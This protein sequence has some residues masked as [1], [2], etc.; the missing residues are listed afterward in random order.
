MQS[1]HTGTRMSVGDDPARQQA[2]DAWSLVTQAPQS[3]HAWHRFFTAVQALTNRDRVQ[4]AAAAQQARYPDA[5]SAFL[6]ST[7]VHGITRDAADLAGAADVFMNS[8]LPSEC[9]LALMNTI[10]AQALKSCGSH[11]AMHRLFE[12]AKLPQV[13]HALGHRLAEASPAGHAATSEVGVPAKRA[14]VVTPAVSYLR[15]HAPTQMAV[16]QARQLRR[17]GWQVSML[18]AQEFAPLQME[19]WLG[20]ARAMVLGAPRAPELAA[21]RT[22]MPVYL[23]PT[24]YSMEVRWRALIDKVREIR[25]QVVL[26]VGLCS[27]I[28]SVLYRDHAVV[29]L[30]T[31]TGLLVAGPHDVALVGEAGDAEGWKGIA[32][33]AH[34]VVHTRR[35]DVDVSSSPRPLHGLG[36]PPDALVW[37]SSGTRLHEEMLPSWTSRVLGALEQQPDAHW[38]IVGV[39]AQQQRSLNIM[40]PRVHFVPYDT[41][42]ASWMAASDIYLAPPRVGGG[43]SVCM[44]MAHGLAVVAPRTGDAGNKL[45][46]RAQADEEGC[47]AALLRYSAEPAERAACGQ[48]LR[49]RFHAVYAARDTDTALGDA[50]SLAQATA[51]QRL[52]NAPRA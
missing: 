36:I 32:P 44:A 29:G 47:F 9:G 14:V 33:P 6:A 16:L 22:E 38:L 17:M 39:D 4:F 23:A 42:L 50:I 31:N 37:L 30:A 45:A 19:S 34:R 10:Q 28:L 13:C 8:R 12:Q 26:F 7:C 1:Y 11:Q 15:Q 49:D 27:P 46:E 3:A 52:R 35:F 43:A 5:W 41:D 48:F 2:K 40:H 24:T 51:A 25:P 18:S 21:L 20:V